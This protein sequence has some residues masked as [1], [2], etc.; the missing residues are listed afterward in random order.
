MSKTRYR[1]NPHTLTFEKITVPLHKVLAN[2]GIRFLFSLV[3]ATVIFLIYS[4]LF[5]TPKE[6]ILKREQADLLVK[7]DLFQKRLME[8]SEVLNDIQKRDNHLYRSIFEAD[9]IPTSLRLGGVGGAN[10]FKQF[11]DLMN[12]EVLINTSTLLDQLSW[13]AYV[14]SK[15]FDEVIDL[16]RNMEQMVLSMPAIQPVSVR[17]LNRISALY[18]Y[19]IDPFTR[20][21][22]MHTGIDFA[23][24]VGTPVYATGNGTVS[25]A[26]YSF[27]GYG[28]MVVIDH[29]FGYQT[30]YAH[31]DKIKVEVGQTVSRSE[32]IGTLGNSGR[33]TGPHLH[34]EVIYRGRTVDPLNFFSDLSAEEYEQMI[35]N[36]SLNKETMD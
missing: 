9:T 1:L 21:R 29:G 31:L 15:S 28:K 3:A 16:A 12:A 17:D 30:V 2:L 11:H 19:R 4:S 13:R 18:G 32:V 26:H 20:T 23:G 24:T 5:S 7:Y 22:K 6:K 35:L 10:H 36:A 27:F 14:Q 8:M 25:A 33:S 34:Y